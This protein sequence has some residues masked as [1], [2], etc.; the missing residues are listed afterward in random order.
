[1]KSYLFHRK[2]SCNW[3]N[4]LVFF[5]RSRVPE[6]PWDSLVT[7]AREMHRRC[8]N[9]SISYV[10]AVETLLHESTPVPSPLLP[11]FQRLSRIDR[12]T[13]CTFAEQC[14]LMCCVIGRRHVRI[15]SRRETRKTPN[16]PHAGR[17]ALKSSDSTRERSTDLAVR[18]PC[19]AYLVTIIV[20]AT[21]PAGVL[22]R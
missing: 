12:S 14:T 22:R 11:V 17:S 9:G 20:L 2:Y 13:V 5:T 6:L 3:L 21:E 4:S 1:M 7:S 8:R 18:E 15:S 19:V 16:A 10:G